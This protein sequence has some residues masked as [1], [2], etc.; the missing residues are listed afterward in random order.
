[1]S[2]QIEVLEN[3]KKEVDEEMNILGEKIVKLHSFLDY[4]K[5]ASEKQKELLVIQK[6][7]MMTYNGI[8]SLRYDDLED[9][10]E[11]LTDR[12]GAAAG[13]Q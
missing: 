9:S 1:M 2:N 11:N 7:A 13:A 12:Q 6:N 5:D 4:P 3:V 8:L 10:I